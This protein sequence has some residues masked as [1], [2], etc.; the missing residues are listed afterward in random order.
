[1]L[2]PTCKRRAMSPGG[3]VEERVF[4]EIRRLCL[5]GLDEVTLLREVIARLRHAV[6]IDTYWA[7]K[8]DPLSGLPTG[9]V[10]E[11]TDQLT[12]ARFFLEHIYFE[13][14]VLEFNWMARNRRPVALF[15]EGTGGNLGAPCTGGSCSVLRALGMR[16][17]ASSP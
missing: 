6:L 10:S 16:H 4:S 12:R 13:D 8:F 9:M 1:M 17:V 14:D 3:A 15:S 7:P 5:S 11:G 2:T